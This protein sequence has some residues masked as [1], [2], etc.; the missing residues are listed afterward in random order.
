[1]TTMTVRS[2][3]TSTTNKRRT[4]TLAKGFDLSRSNS[5]RPAEKLKS[6]FENKIRKDT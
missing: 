4:T 2:N 1:M 3:V 6:E 5:R